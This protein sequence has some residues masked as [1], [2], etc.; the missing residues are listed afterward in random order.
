MK[1]D[2]NFHF[3]IQ[4]DAFEDRQPLAQVSLRA[5]CTKCKAVLEFLGM[6]CGVNLNG[7]AVSPDNREARLAVSITKEPARLKHSHA[8][9]RMH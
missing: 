2:H 9:I 7:P 8:S 4:V 3:D 5:T 6:Q 1:C